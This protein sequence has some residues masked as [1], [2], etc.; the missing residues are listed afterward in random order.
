M[1]RKKRQSDPLA[2]VCLSALIVIL[3]LRTIGAFLPQ[4]RLWGINHASYFNGLFLFYIALATAAFWINRRGKN[5]PV[6]IKADSDLWATESV[7]R[8]IYPYVILV[9]SAMAFYFFAV[10]A[11]FLGDGYQLIASLSQPQLTFKTESYGDMKLHRLVAEFIGAGGR[12]SVHESF[13][14]LSILSGLIFVLAVLYYGRKICDSKFSY[15]AFA[16]LNI[17]SVFTL[18]F[19]GY[20]ETYSLAAAA[21]FLFLLS[22]WAALKNRRKSIMPILAFAAAVF[23]HKVALI[24]AP[25]LLIYLGVISG[26]NFRN[27]LSARRKTILIVLSILIVAVYAA[28][29]AVG[30]LHIKRI[31]LSPLGDRFTTDNY[32][33]LSFRHIL[34][35]LNLVIFMAPILIVLFFIKIKR[36]GTLAPLENND[37]ALR[38]FMLTALVTGGLAAFLIEPKLGMPR[39]WDLFSTMLIGA[40]AFVLYFWFAN[41]SAARLFQPASLMLVIISLS[42]F[43]PWLIL[44]NSRRGLYSYA[45]YMMELDPKH[46]RTGMFTVIP[47]HQKQGNIRE[48][49]RLKRYC[50]VNYPESEWH[51]EGEKNLVYGNYRKAETIIRKTIDENPSFFRSYQTLARI[52]METGR[53]DEALENLHIADALNPY[54]SDNDYYTGLVYQQMGNRERAVYHYNRSIKYDRLNP[55]PYMA[56]A[57]HFYELNE[58]DSSKYYFRALPDTI[59]IFPEDANYKLGLLGLKLNDTVRAMFY[60]DKY[61]SVGNDSTI[62]RNIDSLTGNT[63]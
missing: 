16:M 10:D 32:Y 21:I 3:I 19:Y 6:F 50:A 13:K 39:D 41:Y 5:N 14:Y 22:G 55:L 60:F 61:K 12:L 1:S 54:N 36:I 7:S 46:G 18:L 9:L 23:F 34:D 2:N 56:L 30:P 57:E 15:Y 11:Y 33:L 42:V 8:T 28:V 44:N 35:Y 51:K 26:E 37:G 63:Q 31:F 43:I 27:L 45:I 62:L 53:L 17:L 48:A 24:Y 52:Q 59:D 40:H 25:A 58:F 49:E 47:M 38:L 20:V 29:L 4:A